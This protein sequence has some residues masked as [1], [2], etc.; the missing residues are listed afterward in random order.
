MKSL[1]GRA[2]VVASDHM[3]YVMHT[4]LVQTR[5]NFTLSGT[6]EV[7]TIIRADTKCWAPMRIRRITPRTS[8]RDTLAT[9]WVGEGNDEDSN[10]SKQHA[11]HH[12]RS[13]PT[14]A[15]R[16]KPNIK[17]KSFLPQAPGSHQ[18]TQ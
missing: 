16:A 9:K 7:I 14:S 6:R 18:T 12:R 4:H 15:S 5:E 10:I 11:L 8:S 3:A 17:A 2:A 1:S 13:Q